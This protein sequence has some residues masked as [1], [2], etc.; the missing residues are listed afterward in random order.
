MERLADT[1]GIICKGQLVIHDQKDSVRNVL[2]KAIFRMDTPL[3]DHPSFFKKTPGD[4]HRWEV[5]IDNR[6][7]D[8]LT[9]LQSLHPASLELMDLSLEDV[10]AELTYYH[11]SRLS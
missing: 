11:R 3:P 7:S 2:K 10:F 9:F 6:T 8:G 1:I 4:N 5:I